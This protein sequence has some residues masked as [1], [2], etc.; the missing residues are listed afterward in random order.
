MNDR[1]RLEQLRAL[2]VRLERMPAS[3]E[4]DRILGEVRARAV[5]VETGEPPA[6]MRALSEDGAEPEIPEAPRKRRPKPAPRRPAARA[7]S[8]LRCTGPAPPASRLSVAAAR[9]RDLHESV[10]DLLEQGGVLCLDDQPS[11]AD[12]PIRPWSGGLRG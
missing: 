7:T 1:D 2:L 12:G 8:G 3:A 10:V 4:R 5:D 6:A 11:A 9:Q